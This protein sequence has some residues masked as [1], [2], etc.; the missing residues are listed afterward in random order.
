MKSTAKSVTFV[1][2]MLAVAVAE[3]LSTVTDKVYFDI[4]ID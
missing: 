2:V 1:S 3:T 4:E